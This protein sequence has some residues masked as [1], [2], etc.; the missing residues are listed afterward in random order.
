MRRGRWIACGLTSVAVVVAVLA[1]VGVSAARAPVHERLDIPVRVAD[2]PP[3]GLDVFS[4]D[5]AHRGP[6][7]VLVWIHGGGYIAGNPTQILRLAPE[8]TRA[9]Y[10]VA[11]VGY[12]PAPGRRY[13]TQLRQASAALAYVQRHAAELGVNPHEVFLGGDSA[14]AQIASQL[15]A[16]QG[17]PGLVARVGLRPIDLKLR[18]VVLY[19]GLYDLRTVAADPLARL[20]EFLTDYTG[21]RDW[22]R[23]DELS[24]VRWVN[25]DYPPAFISD[26]TRDPFYPQALELVHALR[27]AGVAVDFRS[28]RGLHHDFQFDDSA[29]ARVSLQRTIEFM[30]AAS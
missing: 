15:A 10:V 21:I 16:I 18:G 25:S 3:A 13:P 5:P 20:D 29:P 1:V 14:G 12:T 7:P 4:P 6:L 2:A 19:C 27:R 9:G 11:S 24:T 22:Q 17:N 23:A 8:L 28:W 30:N 26:A